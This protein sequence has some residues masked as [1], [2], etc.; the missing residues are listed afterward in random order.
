MDHDG[1]I[2]I[3]KVSCV[4][5]STKYRWMFIILFHHLFATF[6]FYYF[7]LFDAELAK[8]S[9]DGEILWRPKAVNAFQP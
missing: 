9:T 5:Q 4:G 2:L 1:Q 6:S 3:T 8:K 7:H